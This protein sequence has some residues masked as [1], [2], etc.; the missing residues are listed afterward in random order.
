MVAQKTK[1]FFNGPITNISA[2]CNSSIAA[3]TS[4]LA[5]C[6]DESRKT[7]LSQLIKLIDVESGLDSF[8]SIILFVSLLRCRSTLRLALSIL[9]RLLCPVALLGLL[10]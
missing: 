6:E 8:C 10:S 7:G 2:T 4:T 9:A 5:A 3:N 1:L